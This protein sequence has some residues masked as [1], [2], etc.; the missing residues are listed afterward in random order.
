MLIEQQ[1][2]AKDL[3]Q[4]G[5]SN[6]RFGLPE[7]S[8]NPLFWKNEARSKGGLHP[9]KPKKLPPTANRGIFLKKHYE[10]TNVA[11]KNSYLQIFLRL[12]FCFKYA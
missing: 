8:F 4:D 6:A 2:N 9:Q 1:Y 11:P 10:K 3:P 7:V 5:W 12:S